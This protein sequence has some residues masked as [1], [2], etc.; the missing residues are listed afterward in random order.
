PVPE[1]VPEAETIA[2]KFSSESSINENLGGKREKDL[3][4]KIKGEPID[5]ISRNIG[6]N[7]RFL[8]IRELFEGNSD[9]FAK[10]ISGLDG[11]ENYQ[12]AIEILNNRFTGS[13]DH[14][15]VEILTGLVKRRFIQA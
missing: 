4:T 2:E 15:G 5:Q 1:P 10:L 11:A 7:D 3:D 13:M 9:E 14:E 6:I 8:I 12:T